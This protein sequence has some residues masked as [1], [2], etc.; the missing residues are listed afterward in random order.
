MRG[1]KYNHYPPTFSLNPHTFHMQAEV[2]LG[3]KGVAGRGLVSGS[4]Q[5]AEAA[6]SCVRRVDGGE[7]GTLTRNRI[8]YKL[9]CYMK[10][11]HCNMRPNNCDTCRQ[12]CG[13]AG[14]AWPAAAS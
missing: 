7:A 4:R 5:D 11:K 1:D 14:K 3:R 6:G 12:R 2:R 8:L 13:W 9:S 10:P